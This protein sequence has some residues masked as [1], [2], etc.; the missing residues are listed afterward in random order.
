MRTRGQLP[1]A[2]DLA[3][4]RGSVLFAGIDMIQVHVKTLAG[5]KQVAQC[6]IAHFGGGRISCPH[7]CNSET[8]PRNFAWELSDFQAGLAKF[9]WPAPSASSRVRNVISDFLAPIFW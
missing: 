6:D 2:T 5:L 7:G 8:C 3:Q 4:M 1:L 9:R